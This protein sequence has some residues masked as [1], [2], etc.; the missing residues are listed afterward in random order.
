[1]LACEAATDFLSLSLSLSLSFT[2]VCRVVRPKEKFIALE[3]IGAVEAI[4]DAKQH[5][6][7][8]HLNERI[9]IHPGIF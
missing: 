3:G 7:Y 2:S 4:P 8:T 6:F 1:M 5:A 9:F